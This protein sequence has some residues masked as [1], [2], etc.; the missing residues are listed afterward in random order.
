MGA[1]V[2]FTSSRVAWHFRRAGIKK[3]G[4]N[5]ILRL[6]A[7][8]WCGARRQERKGSIGFYYLFDGVLVKEKIEEMRAAIAAKLE[9]KKKKEAAEKDELALTKARL[10]RDLFDPGKKEQY[11]TITIDPRL[12]KIIVERAQRKGVPIGQECSMIVSSALSFMEIAECI[13]PGGVP[14]LK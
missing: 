14:T 1:I 5:T 13:V 11:E 10:K 12:K 2:E 8:G 6:A 9:D 3:M 7:S 4:R